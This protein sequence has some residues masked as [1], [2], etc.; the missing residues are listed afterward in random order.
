ML[1]L[2]FI[3]TRYPESFP[4]AS[5]AFFRRLASASDV[6]VAAS[7]APEVVSA[8]NAVQIIT[9]SATVYLPMSDLIDVEKECTRLGGEAAKLEAEIERIG[10]KLANEG[11][12][13]KA[14]E[15]VVAAERA[16]LARYE[17]NLAGVKAALEKL[18]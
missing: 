15:Q 7:F 4:E 8:D 1:I 2:F 9:D 14:P 18:K 12:V 5:Y 10:K 11:F 17:E 16:K 3:E 6:V 13:A